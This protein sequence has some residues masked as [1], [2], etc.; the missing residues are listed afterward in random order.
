MHRTPVVASVIIDNGLPRLCTHVG[1]GLL[2]S[3][4]RCLLTS[5]RACTYLLQRT[6]PPVSAAAAYDPSLKLRW[7]R[8]ACIIQAQ[9]FSDA[10]LAELSNTSAF[11]DATGYN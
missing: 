2:L 8:T 6:S 5:R 10:Y 9:S 11:L 1:I 4:L 3:Q 7:W